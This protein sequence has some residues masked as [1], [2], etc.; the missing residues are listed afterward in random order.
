VTGQPATLLGR[1][2]AADVYAWGAGRVLKLYYAG[3][4]R[5]AVEREYRVTRAVR[6]A[7][8]PAPEAYEVVEIDDRWGVVLERVEGPSLFDATLR[9]PW[10]MLAAVRRLAELHA[11]IHQCVAPA[12]LPTQRER[13][14]EAIEAADLPAAEKAD[15]RR[16]LAALPD[17]TA[18]CHGDFHPGNVLLSAR[19]PV[20]I[21]WDLAGRGHP[22]ADVARTIRLVRNATL[23]P[24]TP[25]PFH[26]LLAA[27][28][29]RIE[30]VYLARYFRRRPGAPAEV[31]GWMLPV[32]AKPR[33]PG[34]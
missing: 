23:P 28:R 4:S 26:W 6:A 32:T 19:G 12:E 21:D 31:E 34:A 3:K 5:A 13:L 29:A 7:G 17:G 15:A 2:F 11:A 8:L 33:A 22:A 9:R 24:G 1:G 14:A 25:R 20:V 16:R 10:R 30:R 18:V 27:T